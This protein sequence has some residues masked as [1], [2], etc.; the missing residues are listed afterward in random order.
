MLIQFAELFVVLESVFKF[1]FD[2]VDILLSGD[3]VQKLI[4]F[5]LDADLF[6]SQLLDSYLSVSEGQLLKPMLSNEVILLN[7]F[8]F[9]PVDLLEFSV[10]GFPPVTILV[11]SVFTITSDLVILAVEFLMEPFDPHSG[12]VE[13]L[14][15]L[16]SS[17][18]LFLED[19]WISSLSLLTIIFVVEKVLEHLSVLLLDLFSFAFIPVL[20]FF[21]P[22][23][24]H[25]LEVC[26]FEF[27]LAD[28]FLLFFQELFKSQILSLFLFSFASSGGLIFR[29]FKFSKSLFFLTKRFLLHLELL[30]VRDDLFDG[31]HVDLGMNVLGVQEFFNSFSVLPLWMTAEKAII[32]TNEGGGATGT[33]CAM[34]EHF[35]ILPVDHVIEHLGCLEKVGGVLINTDGIVNWLINLLIDA[36]LS[37]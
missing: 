25:A 12:F 2:S 24:L 22:L 18:L 29:L 6:T 37:E 36:S 15:G 13:V 1:E 8:N 5:P 33:R 16:L 19:I 4:N 17:S 10:E 7:S 26:L 23:L 32:N 14:V 30:V 31:A 9:I 11:V 20:L 3:G 34:E 28:L 35:E 27:I 21:D